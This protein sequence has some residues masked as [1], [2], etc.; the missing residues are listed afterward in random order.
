MIE[1][2]RL[3]GKKFFL[4]ADLIKSVE[5]TPDTVITLWGNQAGEKLMVKETCEEVI[6][7]ATEYW[8]RIHQEPPSAT[9]ETTER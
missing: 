8:K 4:N 1:L 5:A 7:K 9:I 2:S 3:N 6:Q